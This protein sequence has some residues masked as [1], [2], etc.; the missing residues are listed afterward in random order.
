MSDDKHDARCITSVAI[1]AIL[2]C[3]ILTGQCG[4]NN[5]STPERLCITLEHGH[6]MAAC[7]KGVNS[8]QK[9]R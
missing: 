1:V 3:G 2:V 7:L 8:A 4:M 9:E 5:C 6:D